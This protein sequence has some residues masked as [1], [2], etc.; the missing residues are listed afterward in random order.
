M[1]AGRVLS[2]PRSGDFMCDN[3]RFYFAEWSLIAENGFIMAWIQASMNHHSDN[4]DLPKL[5]NTGSIQK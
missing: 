5:F 1:P 3:A 2:F 4:T